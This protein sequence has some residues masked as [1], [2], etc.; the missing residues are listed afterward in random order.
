VNGFAFGR[1]TTPQSAPTQRAKSSGF[2]REQESGLPVGQAVNPGNRGFF[3]TS[4]FDR[5]P[6]MERPN[7]QRRSC[8]RRDHW[9]QGL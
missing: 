4:A 2:Y 7:H 5:R 1:A 9:S 3:A 6:K 8:L